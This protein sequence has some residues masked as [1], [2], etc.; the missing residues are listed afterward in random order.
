[1]NFMGYLLGAAMVVVA[2]GQDE[3]LI[4]LMWLQSGILMFIYAEVQK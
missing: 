2:I 3:Q 4:S 1:M